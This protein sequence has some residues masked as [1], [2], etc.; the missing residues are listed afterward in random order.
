MIRSGGVVGT[1]GQYERHAS[2][3]GFTAP[4]TWTCPAVWPEEDTN[5]QCSVHPGSR[6]PSRPASP[7]H[8]LS[9]GDACGWGLLTTAAAASATVV[10]TTSLPPPGN[11]LSE[12]FQ[13]TQTAVQPGRA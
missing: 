3:L 6:A 4:T 7:A 13:A 2:V 11:V 8:V 5:V 12:A 10:Y 1:G 9:C